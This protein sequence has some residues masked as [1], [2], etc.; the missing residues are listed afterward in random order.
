MSLLDTFIG[1][2]RSPHYAQLTLDARTGK[3]K[4]SFAAQSED[5]LTAEFSKEYESQLIN[6]QLIQDLLGWF[7]ETA[8][9]FWAGDQ[10]G[11][12]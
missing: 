7:Q 6:G 5:G 4:M 10:S 8:R 2:L 12:L 11:G 9:K 3:L 1:R